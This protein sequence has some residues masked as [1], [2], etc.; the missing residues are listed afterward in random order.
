MKGIDIS[1][2]DEEGREKI[3]SDLAVLA[4]GMKEFEFPQRWPKNVEFIG[5]CADSLYTNKRITLPPSNKKRF[6]VTFG[7]LLP[8]AKKELLNDV[9]NISKHF[10]DIEFIVSYGEKE[11]EPFVPLARFDN[12]IVYHY[13]PYDSILPL[14]DYVIHHGGAGIV[15]SCIKWG[16]LSIVTPKDYDHFD[17]A[18]RATYHDISIRIASLHQENLIPAITN[19]LIKDTTSIQQFRT[20]YSTYHPT[21]RLLSYLKTVLK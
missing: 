11:E 3:Y 16:K 6:F 17:F 5:P 10:R 18:A 15:Y 19:L 14:V 20:V 8:W 13:L 4:L 12:V 9:K 1:L 7:T 21:N 2:Y